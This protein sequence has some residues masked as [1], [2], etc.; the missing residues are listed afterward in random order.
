MVSQVLSQ[1]LT[2]TGSKDPVFQND[3]RDFQTMLSGLQGVPL[4]F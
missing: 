2:S 4:Q 1:D 3:S